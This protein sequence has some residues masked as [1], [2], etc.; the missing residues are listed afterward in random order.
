MCALLRDDI[1]THELSFGRFSS[2]EYVSF[3]MELH[4][5]PSILYVIIYRPP[6]QC[7]SFIDD[8]TEMLS[9]VCTEFDCIIITGDLNVHVDN[10]CD[11]NAKE[12]CAV[13]ETFGLIQ[14]VSEPTHSRGHTLDLLMTKGVNISSVNVVD[15][16]LSD[17]FCVFFE[18]SVIPK[19]TAGPAVVGKETH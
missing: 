14:H 2:F 4:L 9:V 15:V 13:L 19:P 10:V 16:A 11:R 18:L 5:S 7:Q 12:L 3:K 8:F 17:H 6:Q 1:I